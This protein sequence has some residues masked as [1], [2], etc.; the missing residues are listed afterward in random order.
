MYITVDG[1]STVQHTVR[2]LHPDRYYIFNIA[3]ISELGLGKWTPSIRVKTK[4]SSKFSS[5]FVWFSFVVKA[6]LHTSANHYYVL[7][8]EPSG[9]PQNIYVASKGQTWISL[10]W[11]PPLES[12]QNG[13]IISYDIKYKVK[14]SPHSSHMQDNILEVSSLLFFIIILQWLPISYLGDSGRE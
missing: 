9:P 3:T 4:H 11:E 12:E 8:L 5:S 7:F 2:N 1:E 14:N 13:D 10:A 6:L